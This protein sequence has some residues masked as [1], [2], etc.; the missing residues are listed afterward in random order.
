MSRYNKWAYKQVQTYCET[1]LANNP[2]LYTTNTN[3]PFKTIRNTLCHL[4]LSEQL[5]LLRMINGTHRNL[6]IPHA[7]PRTINIMDFPQYWQTGNENEGNY[8]KFFEGL[9]IDTIFRALETSAKDW[10]RFVHTHDTDDE[11]NETFS[12]SST[13]GEKYI[14]IKSDII[15]HVINHST[16]HR[17]QISGALT[18][19]CTNVEPVSLDLPYMLRMEKIAQN[20]AG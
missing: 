4:W 7:P 1:N 10:Q 9:E 12:Y 8:E 3:I 16:H 17:G 2:E 13:K 20:V 5:W 14:N 18:Q 19:L 15:G 11:L 6:L